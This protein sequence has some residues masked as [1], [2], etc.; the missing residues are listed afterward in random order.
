MSD[1][2]K[3]FR[4]LFKAV[5]VGEVVAVMSLISF[6]FIRDLQKLQTGLWYT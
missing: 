6:I 2:Y 4:L 3:S 1:S 5:V